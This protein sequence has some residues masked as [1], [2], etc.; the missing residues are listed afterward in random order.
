MFN[1]F[2][3]WPTNFLRPRKDKTILFLPYALTLTVTIADKVFC[4]IFLREGN[5]GYDKQVISENYV[6]IY[7]L[8]GP[9]H[10]VKL[11]FYGISR[12]K[13]K[14]SKEVSSLSVLN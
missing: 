2:R 1:K 5:G 9:G 14:N 11:E 10:I 12:Q 8:I 7:C 6:T 3:E 4:E 13:L